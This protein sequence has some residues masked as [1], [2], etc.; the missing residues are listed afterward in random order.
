MLAVRESAEKIF[1][2]IWGEKVAPGAGG[3]KKPVVAPTKVRFCRLMSSPL[4]LSRALLY[5]TGSDTFIFI[6]YWSDGS[7]ITGTN[8]LNWLDLKTSCPRWQ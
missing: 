5:T 3:E 7:G 1:K 2:E 8:V 6:H 4:S